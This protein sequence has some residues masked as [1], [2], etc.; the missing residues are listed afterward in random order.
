MALRAGALN[1]AL[2]NAQFL[3]TDKES[4]YEADEETT[5]F[6]SDKETAELHQALQSLAK[7]ARAMLIEE[8]QEQ[9]LQFGKWVLRFWELDHKQ[10]GVLCKVH[11][12][13]LTA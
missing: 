13:F 9:V 2:E 5:G 12:R 7:E 3:L 1:S 11:Q 10:Y 4:S 8:A 6:G